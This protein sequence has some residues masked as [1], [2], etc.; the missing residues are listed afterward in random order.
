MEGW[1][2]PAWLL[3]ARAVVPVRARVPGDF[4]TVKKEKGE[5]A[6]IKP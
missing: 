4:A 1:V 3:G 2:T 6:A 5:G